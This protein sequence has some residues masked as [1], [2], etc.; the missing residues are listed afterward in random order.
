MAKLYPESEKIK[1]Q[2]GFFDSRLIE[3]RGI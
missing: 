2:N 3:N 1:G